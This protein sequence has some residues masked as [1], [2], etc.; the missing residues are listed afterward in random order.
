[1]LNI[2]RV[3]GLIHI[4][5]DQSRITF[6]MLTELHGLLA[7]LVDSGAT[8]APRVLLLTSRQDHFSAGADLLDPA[9]IQRMTSESGRR[10]VAALGQQLVERLY[11]LPIP[12]VVAASGTII[13][14]GACLFSACDFRVVSQDARL[15]FPEVQRGMHLSWG[16]LPI[17]VSRY[18]PTLARDLALVGQPVPVR[19]LPP[20]SVRLVADGPAARQSAMELCASL[21]GHPPLAVGAILSV[22]WAVDQKAMAHA[23]GDVEL[24]ARTVGS[25]DFAEAMAAFFEKRPGH[26]RGR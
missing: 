18:G 15:A 22:L 6:A 3:D 2:T 23:S 9:M 19:H 12:T 13:G 10:E 16:I 25:Q 26:Y 7:T 5:L 17:L 14:A 11:A 8:E 21:A 24:F 20:D 1:M 4:R